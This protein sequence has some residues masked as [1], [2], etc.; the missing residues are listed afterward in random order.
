MDRASDFASRVFPTPGTSSIRTC[1]PASIATTA[2]KTPSRLPETARSTLSTMR[3]T[4]S[5]KPL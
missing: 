2:V 1:P 5:E 3:E 4:L